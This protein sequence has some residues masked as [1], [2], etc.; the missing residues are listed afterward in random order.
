[1]TGFPRVS[2]SGTVDPGDWTSAVDFVNRL[3]W[4]FEAYDLE[5]MINA[6]LPD[7]T[8]HHTHGAIRGATQIR[9]FLTDGYPY[10]IPGVNRHAS[11]H[12]V[13]PDVDGVMVRYQN[14][15]IRHAWP[16][17]AQQIRAG[18]AVESSNN[19]PGIWAYSPVLDRLRSTSDG[20]RIAERHLGGTVSNKALSVP[21]KQRQDIKRFLP[22]SQH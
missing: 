7:A 20:W 22:T 1:M 10:L 9:A 6:F 8:V 15:L 14:L 19:L 3:N 16:E 21:L 17:Q 13:D 11:N 2:V 18:A 12:I 4:L 5:A